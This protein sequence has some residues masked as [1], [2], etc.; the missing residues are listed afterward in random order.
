MAHSRRPGPPLT[1]S[2][3][4]APLMAAPVGPVPP[5]GRESATGS[6]PG[7]D[8]RW[9][10]PDGAVHTNGTVGGT[11]NDAIRLRPPRP[12]YA[13]SAPVREDGATPALLE[14]ETAESG[15]ST[16]G[17][18]KVMPIRPAV[19]ASRGPN[20]DVLGDVNYLSEPAGA[21]PPGAPS[22]LSAG[23]VGFSILALGWFVTG[24]A[25]A[26]F[27]TLAVIN[28]CL[29]LFFMAANGMKLVLIDRSLRQNAPGYGKGAAERI[30]DADL[31]VY[32]ILLPVFRETSVL[33]QLV[34]GIEALDYPKALLDVKLLLEEDDT[35]T[36]DAAA[37]IGLPACFE[38]LVVPDRGPRG[39]PRACNYGL[40][41][42]KG[43]YLVI[44][45]AE[46][47]PDPDQLRMSVAAFRMAAPNVICH[48][49]KLNYFNRRHNLLTRWFTSEYSVWFDQLLP[50]LQSLDVAIP[51]GGTS[52]HF[53]TERL[54]SLG[55]WNPYNVTEDAELGVR[56]Y[57]RGWKTAVLD[58][59]TYEEA[60]SQYRNWIRQ[61]SRWVKG[62]MQT[63]LSCMRRP[64]RLARR[65][66]LKSFVSFQLFFGANTLCL[67]INPIFWVMMAVWF[68]T[69]A[70]WIPSIFPAP[71]FY[72]A[73]VG[74]LVGNGACM[75]SLVSGSVARRH[76]GD[77]KCAF[78][79]PIYWLVMSVAAYKGL[80]QLF[81]KPSYWE[82]T[83]HGICQYEPSASIIPPL[84]LPP[85]HTGSLWP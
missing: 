14:P 66:G 62:Y 64:V 74:L 69:H 51:L 80:L 71:V 2:V 33:R 53:I 65:M 84:G 9:L 13:F 15:A 50:G 67:L 47:H 45:D 18:G 59:T 37:L 28:G 52:N 77:V 56:I 63:Y 36:R 10:Y 29:L 22:V 4:D 16:N 3:P 61:R 7:A 82:K 55:G 35:E 46:D 68:A 5:E 40:L 26:S 30:A 60:T 19:Q 75:V 23:Q 6:P 49:A 34:A 38:V 39:K 41:R 76:Y 25:L 44:F 12:R 81:H 32:T 73:A 1:P 11:R 78:L 85:V 70:G 79:V 42:A 27:L 83:E 24:L 20:G 43:E 58:S 21:P 57:L 48:Q 17:N 8:A 72:L 54:V 31:P